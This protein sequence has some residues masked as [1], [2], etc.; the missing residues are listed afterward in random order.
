MIDLR[1]YIQ[2]I[3][4]L[5]A[6]AA[7]RAPEHVDRGIDPAT[8]AP[9]V[10]AESLHEFLAMCELRGRDRDYV[11]LGV[12]RIA[13][14]PW[15]AGNWETLAADEDLDRFIWTFHRAW[16]DSHSSV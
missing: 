7:E 5:Q 13:G 15:K 9:R 8:H 3:E 14:H 11:A 10:W 4:L 12:G 16:I 2:T 6:V 1:L